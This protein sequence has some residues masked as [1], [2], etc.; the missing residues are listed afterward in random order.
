MNEEENIEQL[1]KEIFQTVYKTG[2]I[3]KGV[4]LLVLAHITFLIIPTLC[5]LGIANSPPK[6]ILSVFLLFAIGQTLFFWLIPIIYTIL[7]AIYF[8]V[9]KEEETLK[10]I[11]IASGITFLLCCGICG[12]M[13]LPNIFR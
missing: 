12:A 9:A 13:I 7:L 8:H 11:L 3:F 4:M 2:S 5:F 6:V 10:G 1:E